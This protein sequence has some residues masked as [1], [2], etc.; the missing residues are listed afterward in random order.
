MPRPDPIRLQVFDQ[1]LA[2]ICEESGALLQRS[3]VSPN[4]RER[5][6]YSV[7]LFDREVRLLAQ[8]AHIPVHLGSA[9]DAVR[10]ARSHCRLGPGDVVIL[11][12]PFAGGTH[13]PDVTL[14]RP[15][16]LPGR[17]APDFYLAN[18]AHHA[19]IGGGVPG[20]MGI[21]QDLLGEGLVIP[22]THLRRRG[23]V[24]TGVLGLFLR[25]VRGAAE[26]K[27]DLAAQEAALVLAERRLG[28]LVASRGR[29]QVLRE[30]QQLL[31]Y[32][33]RIVASVLAGLPRG[34]FHAV[35]ALEDD[36]LG[37]G[38]LPIRL[39]LR[40]DGKRA[41]FDFRATVGAARGAVNANRS[42]VLAAC[43]YALR[44]LCPADMPTNAGLFARLDVLTTPGSLVDPP[45]GAPVA[46][47]NVETSQRLVDV[48]FEALGRALPGRMPACSA[49][50]MS[51]LSL[52]GGTGARAF[53]FYETI[54]GGAGASAHCDG[55][56]A[57]QT[58]M[59]NTRN[60]PVEQMEH[61]WPVR[62]LAWTLRRGSGGAG[63]HAGGDGVRKVIECLTPTTCSLLADRHLQGP[64]G[65]A[66]GEP[67][68]PGSAFLVRRGRRQRV[69][70]KGSWSLATGDVVWIETPGGGG[71]GA[72]RRRLK[73]NSP[74]H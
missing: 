14:V 34:E 58:H 27:I 22:P 1:L 72:P 33:E 44:C 37:S 67:G 43:V 30:S 17:A 50:T 41:R 68:L 63:R 74:G 69:A 49:G 46:A 28:E 73:P 31:A 56:S 66:R 70:A 71:H 3:A 45:D 32:A 59:T 5:R 29:A 42:I 8:A 13:L 24:D 21:A 51:N 23:V 16:F 57:V 60:T 4:I 6:D 7:A 62:V 19:D 61:S 12:D 39:R 53:A 2:A 55:T 35:D 40:L 11:N 9:G 15:V 20:S 25:N 52:G 38:P 26:R 36:G 64:P 54:P 65:A 47:G 18:R 48:C 10:A